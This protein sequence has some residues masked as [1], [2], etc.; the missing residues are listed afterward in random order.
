M[1]WVEKHV[2]YKGKIALK[3]KHIKKVI[4]ADEAFIIACLIFTNILRKQVTYCS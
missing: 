1:L 4:Y 2:N 3:N